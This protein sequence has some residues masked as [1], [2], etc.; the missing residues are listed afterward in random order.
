[1]KELLNELLSV[2]LEARVKAVKVSDGDERVVYFGS[3]KAAQDAITAG[4]HRPYLPG[5]KNLPDA[6]QKP[7]GSDIPKGLLGRKANPTEPELT[8]TP[9]KPKPIQAPDKPELVTS[10]NSEELKR[11]EDEFVEDSGAESDEM[12]S[13]FDTRDYV[14]RD[15]PEDYADDVYYSKENGGRG[16]STKVRSQPFKFDDATRSMLEARGFPVKY[17]KL[18][19]RCVNTQ[20]SGK[21]PP[22]TELVDVGGAGQIASQFGEVISM[23]MMCLPPDK[24]AEFAQTMQAEIKKSIEEVGDVIAGTK[25]DYNKKGEPTGKSWIDAAITHAEAF[26]AAMDEIYGEGSWTLEGASWDIRS[27]VEALG[28]PYENKGFS[29]DVIL[30]V[31][32]PNGPKAQ[33]VSLKKDENIMFFNGSVNEV[34]NFILNYTDERSRK[35]IKGLEQLVF[36]AG[37]GNKNKER[38]AEARAAL[39]K[40][41]GQTSAA[42]ALEQTKLE[43]SKLRDTALKNAPPEVQQLVSDINSFASTQLTAGVELARNVH[44]RNSDTS[45]E[46]VTSA[47]EAEFSGNEADDRNYARLAWDISQQCVKEQ[48]FTNCVKEKLKAAGEDATTDRISKVCVI[49]GR[50][51]SQ[52]GDQKSTSELENVYEIGRDI[53]RR[54]MEAIP[55]HNE[56]MGGVMQKLASSFPLKVCMSGTEMMMI[57]GIKITQK[58]LKTVF[59]TDDYSTLEKKLDILRLPTGESILV[60]QIEGSD[61]PISIGYVRGR[62]KGLGYEGTVGF[63]IECSDDFA[64]ACA[65]A[66][67]KNGDKSNSNAEAVRR[68]S[69]RKTKRQAKASKPTE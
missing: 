52:L 69:G 9:D 38:Q 27:D 66:N 36:L 1:M 60:Y 54:L 46:Q 45:E 18:L 22:V 20:I 32:T 58:T 50:I 67:A 33:R 41:T 37:P 17:I 15:L 34:N 25:K 28:L 68:I 16:H 44:T 49:T 35:R 59:G 55:E 23:A 4:T 31:N 40:L 42:K 3:Q 24:R 12:S 11:I 14:Q 13:E 7:I 53:G 57:D 65:E 47:I 64:L 39:L 8:Q 62:Q 56:L 26:D 43:I 48:N 10:L 19:E 61:Q 21:K 51:A 5:D 2:I 6:P 29:T 63:E 30:R